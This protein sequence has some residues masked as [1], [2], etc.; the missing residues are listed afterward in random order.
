MIT[1]MTGIQQTYTNHYMTNIPVIELRVSKYVGNMRAHI[2]I[3]IAIS[4]H[5]EHSRHNYIWRLHHLQLHLIIIKPNYWNT[6][7]KKTLHWHQ[8]VSVNHFLTL[9]IDLKHS[10]SLLVSTQTRIGTFC[11][12]TSKAHTQPFYMYTYTA[13]PS[14]ET[15]GHK[16]VERPAFDKLIKVSNSLIN[17]KSHQ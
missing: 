3:R 10:S 4:N 2:H 16:Y 17:W 7:N 13:L 12:G 15:R 1:Y 8:Y 6:T 5:V 9:S 11:R 14:Y